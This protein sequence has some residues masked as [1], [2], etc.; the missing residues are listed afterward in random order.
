MVARLPELA[1]RL[2]EAIPRLDDAREAIRLGPKHFDGSGD[3]ADSVAGAQL[4]LGA[5][6]L[7]IASDL[8]ELSSGG[9]STDQAFGVLRDRRGLYDPELLEALEQNRSTAPAERVTEVT[10]GQLRNGM[11]LSRDVL[12]TNGALLVGRGHVVTEQLV[13]RLSNYQRA[14]GVAEP[15]FVTGA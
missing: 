1:A 11:R 6:I 4:P 14:V 13:Q 12:A 9:L 15:L 7:R 8:D 2:L 10:V 5:R 3:P